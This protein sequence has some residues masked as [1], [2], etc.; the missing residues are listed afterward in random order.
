MA[1]NKRKIIPRD[2][3]WLSFNAR[4]LQEAADPTVPLRER[5]RFLA[6]FSNNLDEFFRV[7]V[8]TLKRMI[9]YGSKAKMHL[10]NNPENIIEEIQMSV[11]NHQ[12]EFNRIW[13]QILEE[14]KQQK[15]FLITDNDLNEQQRDFVTRFYEE[16]VSPNVIPLMIETIPD[17]PYLRDKSIYLGV[18][19]SKKESALKR[20]YSIIEV[21][22]RA[23]SRFVLLPSPEDEHHIILL[24]DVIRY[25]LPEIFS[26]FGYDQYHSGVF[27]VTRDAEIDIDNDIST[28]LIQKI[29]KGLKNRRKGKP[30]RFIYDKEMDPGLLEFLIRKFNLTKRDNIIPGGRI[31]NFRHFMDFPKEVFNGESKRKKPIDHPSLIENRVTDVVLRKDVMLHFPYHSFNPVIDLLREAA[32]DPDVTSIKIT[33]YRLAKQSKVINALINAVRN[34]KQVTVMLELRARFDEEANLGWKVRLEDEGVKVLIGIPNMKVH[35]KICVIRKRVEDRIVQYGFVSTGN[36]NEDTARVYADH[37]LLTSNRAIMADVNRIFNYIEHYKTG[38]HFLKACTTLLPS[39]NFGR[40]EIIKMIHTEV[41][42]AMRGNQAR[43]IAKMNS[44][45]DEEIINELY[46]A[47]KAGVE[48]NLIIRGIFCMVTESTRFDRPVKAISVVDEYLEH[49]RVWIFHNAGKEKVFISSAD[50]MIR[51]LDHRVEASCPIFDENIKKEISDIIHIQLRDNVKARWL[52]NELTNEYVQ[53]DGQQ[54]RSQVETA[55]YLQQKTEAP[56]ETSSY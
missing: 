34:G 46:D 9:Q 32:I 12:T 54:V 23:Q 29:E 50:W 37:C 15:I 5:I 33:C 25:N 52:N 19:M 24:E 41:K 35:A 48:I 2:I 16:E 3:S 18:V 43:I 4:V 14:M 10:E 22:T 31:H 51:N 42:N 39:P 30:V 45:S 56:V 47:A 7:R 26:Y 21:P 36:L 11:L 44:L 1:N 8:A 13:E 38:T 49:A 28:T 6:I 20:L 53:A 55:L 27:K 40:R 17:F